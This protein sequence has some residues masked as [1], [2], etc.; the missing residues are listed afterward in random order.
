MISREDIIGMSGLEEDEVDALSEH[1]H[2]PDTAAA[3]FGA[4]L[5]SEPDGARRIVE[6]IRDDIRDAWHRG[7]RA[8]ARELFAALHHFVAVH[9]TQL[10]EPAGRGPK[11]P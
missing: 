7:D 1:E 8:H 2:I 10:L 3:A 5:L 11:A 9:R 6:M 4:W